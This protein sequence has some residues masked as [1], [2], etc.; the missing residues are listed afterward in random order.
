MGHPWWRFGP[1]VVAAWIGVVGAATGAAH[2]FH[3][4]LAEAEYNV[5]SGR[6]EV[7]L[8]IYNPADLE[9]VLGLIA[10]HRVDLE[11]TPGVDRLIRDYLERQFVVESPDGRPAGLTWVGKEVDLKTAWLYFEVDLPDGPEGVAFRDRL[12]FEVEPD[13]VNTINFRSGDRR[14]TLRFTRDRDRQVLRW[15]DR[16]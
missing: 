1:A 2:P 12:L 3:V 7:A 14:G 8:R 6:L 11:A 4:T 10:G 13:Q 9:R 5:E 15:P 16:P